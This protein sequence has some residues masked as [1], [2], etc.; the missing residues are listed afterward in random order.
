[1]SGIDSIGDGK[2]G[3]A[4]RNRAEARSWFESLRDRIC[5]EVEP[6]EREAPAELF[7]GA[8]AMFTYKPWTRGTGSGSGTGGYFCRIA[9]RRVAS[10]ASKVY[11]RIARWS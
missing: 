7:S 10:V 9:A 2:T 8:P 6:L 3:L 11:P 1:M 4:E 5:A